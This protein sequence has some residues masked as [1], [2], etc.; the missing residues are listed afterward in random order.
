MARAFRLAGAIV[1]QTGEDYFQIGVT[2]EPC[3]YG[4]A[5]FQRPESEP[6]DAPW[7]VPLHPLPA[8]VRL[9]PPWLELSLGGEALAR[10]L[11]ERFVIERNGSV[12]ERLWRLVLAGG[13]PDADEEPCERVDAR[14]LGEMPSPIWQLIRDT[15]LRCI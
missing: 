2:K 11:S 4:E 7:F 1:A 6:G 10:T 15:V 13:D 8:R 12:S 5:G 14:W 3:D 9:S